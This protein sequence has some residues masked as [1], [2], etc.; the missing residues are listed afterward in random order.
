MY[1]EYIRLFKSLS[2]LQHIVVCLTTFIIPV[3]FEVVQDLRDTGLCITCVSLSR[4]ALYFVWYQIAMLLIA[5]SIRQDKARVEEQLQ[6]V[7]KVLTDSVKEI[8]EEHQKQITGVQDRVSDLR[9]WV[10]NI[11][12]AMRNELG[13]DLPPPTISL[14][15]RFTAEPATFSVAVV[16]NGPQGRKARLLRWAKRQIR[17]LKRWVH[18]ILVDWKDN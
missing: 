2:L 7:H 4:L 8:S 14:R 11:D 17:R 18:K 9:N 5:S 3:S 12:R 6:Q 15:G 10:R 13:I 16:T 1:R